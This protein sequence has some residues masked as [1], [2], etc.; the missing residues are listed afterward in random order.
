MAAKHGCKAYPQG[1]DK[2]DTTHFDGKYGKL[3][4]L[5]KSLLKAGHRS[6]TI[7]YNDVGPYPM[8]VRHP[9]K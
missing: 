5:K 8:F 7:D 6:S 9:K 1:D 3:V 2:S 4:A